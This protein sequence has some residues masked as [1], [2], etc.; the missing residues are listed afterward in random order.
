MQ[1]YMTSL[2]LLAAVALPVAAQEPQCQNANPQAQAA[3]NTMVDATKA[4]HP[5]AGMIVS[6]GNPVLGTAGTLGGVG[7]VSA[8]LRRNALKAALPDPDN[9]GPNPVASSLQG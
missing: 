8:T 3:C 1:A 9:A 7:R 5:L 4:F 2:V 6:G